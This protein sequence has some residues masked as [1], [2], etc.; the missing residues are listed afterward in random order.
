LDFIIM[1]P[2]DH[3]SQRKLIQAGSGKDSQS[4][5]EINL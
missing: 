3:R 4:A 2:L 1:N 5:A